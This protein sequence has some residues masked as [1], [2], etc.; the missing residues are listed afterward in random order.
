M[1]RPK[2]NFRRKQHSPKRYCLSDQTNRISGQFSQI[3]STFAQSISW[4]AVQVLNMNLFIFCS[5]LIDYHS[6]KVH[7][8]THKTI[9]DKNNS[10]VEGWWQMCEN[11]CVI[12]KNLTMEIHN[13]ICSW[14]SV[15]AD[16]YYYYFFQIKYSTPIVYRH[17][18]ESPAADR[19][20]NNNIIV[21]RTTENGIKGFDRDSYR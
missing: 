17:E 4:L 20:I 15:F 12:I 14:S 19:I 5:T 18:T 8:E 21:Y 11:Q 13:I 16:G 3:R 1:I 7:F 2:G 6:T 9:Y 10:V